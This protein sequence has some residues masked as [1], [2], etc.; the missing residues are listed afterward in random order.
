VPP[1]VVFEVD[2]I[3]AEW[4]FSRPFDYIH[5]RYLTGAI[6]D[7]PRLM[8]QAFKYTKPGGWVEF[9][10]FDMRFYSSDHT[11]VPGC[12]AEEWGKELILGLKTMDFEPE[13]GPK[14]EKWVT[15]AGFE[16]IHH[17]VLAIPVGIWPKDRRM[18]R[19][20]PVLFPQPLM[21]ET[22]RGRC[23]QSLNVP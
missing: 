15:E 17:Q 9:Q 18:V 20:T 3:E 16:N 21:L 22:E 4:C 14:L 1:N 5:C 7:W 2:D 23:V 19:Y 6:S 11:F 12:A 13:P 8:E 10:D